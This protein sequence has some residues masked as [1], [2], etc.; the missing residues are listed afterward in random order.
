MEDPDQTAQEVIPIYAEE[1]EVS[2]R[3]VKTGSGVRIHKTVTQTEKIVDYPLL[4]E[5]SDVTRVAVNRVVQTAP[6]IRHE[7]DLMIIPVMEEQ[8]VIE[9]RL[10]LKEEIH[11]RKTR[12]TVRQPQS[13]TLREEHAEVERFG[14]HSEDEK[15][16]LRPPATGSI[17]DRVFPPRRNS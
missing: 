1:L 7:G 17:L 13:I 5:S 9:K 14:A 12:E 2:T 10:V 8:L 4:Y 3:K 15:E 11:I 6:A 16:K